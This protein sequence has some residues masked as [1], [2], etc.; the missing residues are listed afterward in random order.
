[1][2][3]RETST[4]PEHQVGVTTKRENWMIRPALHMMIIATLCGS[5]T[6]AHSQDGV[7][8]A[9]SR[10]VDC[11]AFAGALEG[12]YTQYR[13]ATADN[14][15]FEAEK[16]ANSFQLTWAQ[17]LYSRMEQE[18]ERQRDADAIKAQMKWIYLSSEALPDYTG[19]GNAVVI[20]ENRVADCEGDLFR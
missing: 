3:V 18:I 15:Y 9:L 20:F 2:T 16:R 6:H 17:I 11:T 4:A 5:A 13:K 8:M 7:G 19:F 1:M 10:L 12:Y 14:Q